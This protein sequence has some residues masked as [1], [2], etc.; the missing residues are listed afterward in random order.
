MS[1][2]AAGDKTHGHI[3]VEQGKNKEVQLNKGGK[4]M[5][6][7]QKSH[8]DLWENDD[9]AERSWVDKVK[10]ARQSHV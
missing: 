9:K 4:K 1:S 7:N 6:V 2:T 8:A 10:A 5:D 3:N